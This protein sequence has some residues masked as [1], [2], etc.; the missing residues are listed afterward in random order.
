MRS[1]LA[2]MPHDDGHQDASAPDERPRRRF[3]LPSVA[4]LA[5]ELRDDFKTAPFWQRGLLVFAVALAGLFITILGLALTDGTGDPR[6]SVQARPT[7]VP[8]AEEAVDAP[9][10]PTREE[11]PTPIPPAAAAENREDCAAIRGQGYLS[12]AEREW[13]LASC[14]ESDVAA[15]ETGPIDDVGAPGPSS[16]TAAPLSTPTAPPQDAFEGADAI[17]LVVGYFASAPEASYMI[18]PASCDATPAAGGAWNVF[19]IGVLAGCSRPE[20]VIGLNACVG[21]QTLAVVPGSC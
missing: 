5:A 8:T 4:T 3:K 19:C 20:C 13:F 11:M 15:A 2:L 9:P 1:I 12:E 21:A 14:P 18:N 7:L 16:P 10:A 6:P 17:A